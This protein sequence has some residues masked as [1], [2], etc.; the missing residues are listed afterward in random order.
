M[1]TFTFS[2]SCVLW[3]DCLSF[4]NIYL[5]CYIT[6]KEIK[7]YRVKCKS[8]VCVKAEMLLL[9]RLLGLII[10]IAVSVQNKIVMID[11]LLWIL[12]WSTRACCICG[13]VGH[14]I[15]HPFRFPV[16][17]DMLQTSLDS[18]SVLVVQSWYPFNKNCLQAFES[19][20]LKCA[21]K[22]Y[23][24]TAGLL[25][26]YHCPY[27]PPTEVVIPVCAGY[28]Q[29]SHGTIPMCVFCLSFSVAHADKD[30]SEKIFA[31]SFVKLMRY[32][33]T[34]LRDG[35]HDLIVYKVTCACTHAQ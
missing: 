16:S 27:R 9:I 25:K 18:L 22:A 23:T 32:D 15:F 28:T 34:T 2:H 10:I 11:I 17:S 13:H 21:G 35:E 3:D 8:R 26:A 5:Y 1:T 19:K 4:V 12:Y 33:G 20:D 30:R 24:C 14:A 7:A 29:S 31:L 6:L